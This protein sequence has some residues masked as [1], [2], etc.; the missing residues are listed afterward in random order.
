MSLR[1][2]STPPPCQ[3]VFQYDFNGAIR[4]I[5]L[6]KISEEMEAEL[7]QQLAAKDSVV[8]QLQANLD[9]RD[10]ELESYVEELEAA[11]RAA[12]QAKDEEAAELK[13]ALARAEALLQQTKEA[14]AVSV[15]LR[16]CQW[17]GVSHCRR[18]EGRAM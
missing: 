7:N 6:L 5:E 13:R 12:L 15:V 11:N 4:Y 14:A 1:A 3:T 17:S 9:S 8:A 10:K 2:R 18:M 16:E